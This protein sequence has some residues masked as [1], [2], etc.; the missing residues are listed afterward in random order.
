MQTIKS[1]ARQY[2]DI[3]VARNRYGYRRKRTGPGRLIAVVVVLAA[4][5]GGAWWTIFHDSNPPQANDETRTPDNT[6]G[7]TPIGGT[8]AGGTT[9]VGS[10]TGGAAGGGSTTSGA[11]TGGTATG[12]AT[13]PPVPK[14][15][16]AAQRVTALRYC[17]EGMKR[18]E[19]KKPFEARTALSFAVLSGHL[20]PNR[21]EEAVQALTLLANKYI[22]SPR[23]DERDVYAREHVLAAGDRLSTLERKLKLHVPWQAMI[24]V[25]DPGVAERLHKNL[26]ID[27]G[28]LQ[29]KSR[30][31]RAGQ[32]LKTIPGP[33]HA[34]IYKSRHLMDL[35][36]HRSGSDKV[37]LRRVLV[38]LG[39]YKGTPTGKWKIVS[40]QIKPDYFPA[41]NSPLRKNGRIAY[42]KPDYAFGKKGLWLGLEGI[43]DNT[44]GR[45]G[46]G[47]HST[48]HQDSIGKDASEGCIRVGDNDIDLVFCM[49]YEQWATVEIRP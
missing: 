2:G 30:R 23:I 26:D 16:T 32:R 28:M 3:D 24:I 44:K 38:G 33:C 7:V 49:L 46:Y 45:R 25:S 11:T 15:P 13:K 36:F 22:L 21:D 9:T 47:I 8:P 6:N 18:L 10:T 29:A 42:G 34:I 14:K 4:I 48:G 31:V 35:Y 1:W 41:P 5:G 39:K 40:K 12:G 27:M 17:D 43:D 19:A 37:F 20:P